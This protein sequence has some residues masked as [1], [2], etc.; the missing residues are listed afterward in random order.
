MAVALL[1]WSSW[2]SLLTSV[3]GSHCQVNGGRLWY[4]GWTSVSPFGFALLSQC[5][6]I[7]AQNIDS[8]QILCGSC[9]LGVLSIIIFVD[10][11]S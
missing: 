2:A 11:D 4:I 7:L 9:S 6:A 8:V 5:L 1:G 10:A 3:F